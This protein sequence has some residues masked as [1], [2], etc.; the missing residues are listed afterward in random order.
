MFRV[1]NREKR[2][3][4]NIITTIIVDFKEG[5]VYA[6]RQTT[7]THAQCENKL[8]DTLIGNK[9]Y[10]VT[11]LYENQTT[12]VHKL[13]NGIIFSAAGS[14]DIID[15]CHQAVMHNKPLPSPTEEDHL[16]TTILVVTKTGDAENATI[17]L[18]TYSSRR[19]STSWYR[20]QQFEWERKSF[21]KT[22]GYATLGSGQQYAMGALMAGAT[23]EEAIV[24][25]S[26]VCLYTNADV[27]SEGFD[28]DIQTN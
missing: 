13:D 15:K 26:K 17:T 24:A 14:C 28:D 25:T 9:V 2:K 3:R 1:F 21:K 20:E 23:P 19:K 10:G 5:R 16:G 8:F 4:R 27:Q 22:E 12:K 6:D 7:N 18:T 11:T